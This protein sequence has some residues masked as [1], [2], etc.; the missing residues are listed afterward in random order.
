M[1]SVSEQN[2]F[3]MFFSNLE[4]I[5]NFM[6]IIFTA[7]ATIIAMLTYKNAKKSLFQPLHTEV[8]K[9]QTNLF[10]DVYDL[11][12]ENVFDKI[13]YEGIFNLCLYGSLNELGYDIEP[14]DD[15]KLELAK[16]TDGNFVFGQPVIED[17]ECEQDFQDASVAVNIDEEFDLVYDGSIELNERSKK[18]PE[19]LENQKAY[20]I[21]SEIVKGMPIHPLLIY[22]TDKNREFTKKLKFFADDPLLPSDFK[23]ELKKL[24]DDI[25]KNQIEK[26]Y[27]TLDIILNRI[28]E[29]DELSSEEFD[30]II[31]EEY[32]RFI[33]NMIKHDDT[34]SKIYEMI[35]S[36]LKVDK[37]FK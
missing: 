10:V 20:I 2:I 5:K 16:C 21:E 13:D 14:P 7:I 18:R 27:H 25:L 24:Y 1:E 9:R 12:K 28:F 19:F 22:V 17:E 37:L 26:M 32:N 11:L 34:I 33:E 29:K 15:T 8:I 6:W 36:Y 4:D 3:Q 31:D 30:S 35:N 23:K